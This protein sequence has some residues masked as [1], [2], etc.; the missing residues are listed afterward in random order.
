MVFSSRGKAIPKAFGLEAA[1][2]PT[3][4][5]RTCMGVAPDDRRRRRLAKSREAGMME[6]D[7]KH[8]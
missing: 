1:T 7:T 2:Q 6:L 3:G 5:S 4:K 8:K